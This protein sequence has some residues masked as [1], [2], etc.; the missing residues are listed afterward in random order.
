MKLSEIDLKFPVLIY[1]DEDDEAPRF[2][3]SWWDIP[4]FLMEREVV[5]IRDLDDIVEVVLKGVVE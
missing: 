1:E 5:E 4:A 2:A 3:R